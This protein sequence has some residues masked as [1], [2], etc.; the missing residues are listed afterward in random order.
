MTISVKFIYSFCFLFVAFI[1][2][3]AYTDNYPPDFSDLAAR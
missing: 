2:T 1:S 3:P